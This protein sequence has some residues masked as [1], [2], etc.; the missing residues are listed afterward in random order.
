[1]VASF[2]AVTFGPLFYR[3][4]DNEKSAALREAKGAYDERMR[5]SEQGKLDLIWWIDNIELMAARINGSFFNPS[6]FL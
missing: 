1:M 6:V 2:P 4:L 3:V 5:I